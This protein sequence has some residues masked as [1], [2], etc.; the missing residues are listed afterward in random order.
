MAVIPFDP[1]KVDPNP[2]GVSA[3]GT[4][5]CQ[6]IGATYKTDIQ[7]R[8]GDTVEALDV[9]LE[10]LSNADGSET[11][12][13]GSRVYDRIWGGG[14]P[15]EKLG[16]IFIAAGIGGEGEHTDDELLN[17]VV[18]ADIRSKSERDEFDEEINRSNVVRYR[19][20]Q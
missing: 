10:I 13:A 12:A 7:T 2:R 3:S 11:D 15:H 14:Q 5:R 19:A 9:N 16:Q 4:F 18:L 6:I 1:T 17:A 8:K 20:A